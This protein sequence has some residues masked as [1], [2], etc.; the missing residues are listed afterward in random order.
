MMESV[1]KTIFRGQ[2]ETLIQKGY[3]SASGMTDRSFRKLLDGLCHH[4]ESLKLKPCDYAEGRLPFVIVI[5]SELLPTAAAMPLVVRSGKAG[6]VAMQP[7]KPDDF[8]PIAGV[9]IPEGMAYL[10]VDFDRGRETLN[11]RPE[12]ALKIV[13]KKRR[14][15]LTIDEGIAIITQHPDFLQKNNCFSLLASRR[16]DQRVPAI[17]IDGAK[18]P[19]LGWCWDR[20]PHTWLGAASCKQRLGA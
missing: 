11:V 16:A 6:H 9:V 3:A 18:R 13:R 17:W 2:V 7:V 8:A 15:P 4:V 12:D 14:S 10:L 1:A 5:K 20:N 19:K